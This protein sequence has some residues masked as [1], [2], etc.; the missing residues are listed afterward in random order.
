MQAVCDDRRRFI[1]VEISH[2][3]ST[4]DYLAFVTSKISHKL[5]SKGLLR[6]GLSIYGDNAYMNSPFMTTPFKAVSCGVR[7][8]YNFYHSQLRINVECSFGMLVNRWAILRTPIPL[9]VSLKKT[10]ALVRA[11]CVLHNFL[12]DEK[13]PINSIR[14]RMTILARG[15]RVF[16]EQNCEDVTELIGGGQH[17]DDT[18]RNGRRA[19]E[20]RL[21]CANSQHPREYLISKLQVLGINARPQPMGSTTTNN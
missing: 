21:F 2:P 5:E 12:I 19:L 16:N 4:S 9:N 17:F 14:D 15:G 11:L 7:D 8:A 1:D 10:T 6:E 13:P 18:S 20:K 3:A